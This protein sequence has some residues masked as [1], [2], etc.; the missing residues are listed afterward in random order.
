MSSS[1][2]Y[3]GTNNNKE[4]EHKPKD[5]GE[6]KLLVCSGNLGNAQ[7]DET[8]WNHWVPLDGY[9]SEVIHPHETQRYPFRRMDAMHYA[10]L[11]PIDEDRSNGNYGEEDDDFPSS[12]QFDLIIFGMQESTFD[13]TKEND[14]G[15]DDGMGDS[16]RSVVKTITKKS[17]KTLSAIQTLSTSRDYISKET[18]SAMKLSSKLTSSS[19][20]GT[21]EKAQWLGG[22]LALHM[23]MAE[24]LP[25]YERVVSFQR[26]EMRLE[27]LAH[28]T[29][30][31]VQVVHVAAQN[32][33][34][35]GLANKGGIVAELLVNGRTRLSFLTAHLE[36][37]EGMAKYQTRV[38][39]IA[40][41]LSGTKHHQH[42][43]SQTAHYSFVMGDLN[44]RTEMPNHAE[45]DE[46]QHKQIVRDMVARKDWDALNKIDELQR[47][48][49]S[50][51][52]LVGYHT[53]FCNF[54]PTF[55]VERQ[56]GYE[57]IDK[58]RPSY[59]DRILWKTNHGYETKLRPLIY[60]PIDE[61]SS[62]DHKPVRAAFSVNL[63]NPFLLR[64]KMVRRRSALN[65]SRLLIKKKRGRQATASHKERFHLFVADM[66]CVVYSKG[67][68]SLL[69]ID[70][71]H[72]SPYICLITNPPEALQQPVLKGWRRIKQ[73]LKKALVMKSSDRRTMTNFLTAKGFPRS[74][75]QK[76]TST[77]DWGDEEIHAEVTTH[78]PDGSP[79]DL[80]GSM[81]HFTVM[82]NRTA[83]SEVVI[84][85][86]AYN[87]ADLIQSR[88]PS[89][90]Q[91]RGK[92]LSKATSV[93][94]GDTR[95]RPNRRMSLMNIFGG[96]TS[97]AFEPS[98][99]TEADP[100]DTI[101]IDEPIVKNGVETGRIKLKLEAWWMDEWTRKAFGSKS[102]AGFF[103]GDRIGKGA[104]S[105]RV[106]NGEKQERRNGRILQ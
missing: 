11:A 14:G 34:R 48:L 51:E 105:D 104:G 73:A 88:R 19:M 36:A 84:G 44:F 95:N 10:S 57:Y 81:L 61:F 6:I 64:P 106:I 22:T 79:I 30:T 56:V 4:E 74:S 16:H 13:Q 9:C 96:K 100:M 103:P 27:I 82:D 102:S 15:S 21:P 67:K 98:E 93:R 12:E 58:R 5:T 60:E 86:F 91:E 55:K 87:M 20:V 2:D 52:C 78:C 47:A 35:A 62:S 33:G 80:S 31:T 92:A 90:K 49:K 68:N 69:A 70:G 99:R 28:Q 25:S 76:Q 66:S 101:E 24:R 97:E 89:D 54:P 45:L 59:T 42:D 63:V 46:E 8:S 37:H 77:A 83:T 1:H 85:S 72:P 17:N 41:I 7:P 29:N 75:A 65:M 40:D 50:K 71:G 3:S 26:G 94:S 38:S 23:L 18:A 32:T 53:L 43:C 39:T